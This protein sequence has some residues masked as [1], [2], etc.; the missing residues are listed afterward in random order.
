MNFQSPLGNKRPN[1]LLLRPVQMCSAES[2]MSFT[3]NSLA[4]PLKPSKSSLQKTAMFVLVLA[5][6]PRT[7]SCTSPL[8]R[9]YVSG[10]NSKA[11]EFLGLGDGPVL[12]DVRHDRRH[13]YIKK[14]CS[15][16]FTHVKRALSLPRTAV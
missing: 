7:T 13:I 1:S 3:T 9:L 8:Q 14:R 10:L 2:W 5:A 4:E 6:S 11:F 15:D 16:W 12:A